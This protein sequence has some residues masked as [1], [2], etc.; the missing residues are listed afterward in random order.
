M[1][2]GFV[3]ALLV[4]INCGERAGVSLRGVCGSTWL[5][6]E[7]QRVR[8]EERGREVEMFVSWRWDEDFVREVLPSLPSPP[9]YMEDLLI[10]VSDLSQ[11]AYM[12]RELIVAVMACRENLPIKNP[13]CQHEQIPRRDYLITVCRRSHVPS[14]LSHSRFT[15]LFSMIWV[16]S[17]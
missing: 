10:I 1:H 7:V 6:G 12:L 17:F 2:R 5:G 3:L 13:V 14:D 8:L 9:Y 4:R 15:D 16:L 11:L